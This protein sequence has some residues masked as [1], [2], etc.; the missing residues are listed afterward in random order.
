MIRW[1]ILFRSGSSWLKV[2]PFGMRK[3]LQWIRDRFNNPD[4]I[5]TENGY[6]DNSG[7]LDDMMRVYYYKHNINNVLKG[8]LI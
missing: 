2:T 8:S 6:S 7:N 4:I 1:C 3:T 5:I